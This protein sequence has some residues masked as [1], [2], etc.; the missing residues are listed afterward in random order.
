MHIVM[1]SINPLFPGHVMGGASKHLQNIAIHLG[2]SGHDVTVLCT[3]REDTPQPFHWHER[4]Q[5]LPLLRFKTPVSQSYAIPAYD[6]A[7]AIQ[8]VGEYLTKADR[9]YIHDGE[10]LFPYVFRH[11]P[12]VV[13]LRDNIYPETLLGSFLFQSDTLILIS[14]Y[15]KAYFE[16]TVGRFFPEYAQRIKV[17]YNGI[18]WE[19]FCPV[20]PTKILELI[21]VDPEKHVII[22]HPHRP[23][24][25]KGI[26]QTIRVVDLL[27]HQYGISNIRILVP[28]SL[29]TGLSTDLRAFYDKIQDDIDHRDLSENFIFHAWMSQELMPEYYS[30]GDVTLALGSFVESFGNA[31]YESLGCGTP[32]VVTR[33]GSHREILPENLVDKVDFG[34][35]E[36]TAE[37][38]AR[39]IR[40]KERTSAETLAYLRQNYSVDRQLAAYADTILNARVKDE[41]RYELTSLDEKTYFH[42]APW[43][44]P[45]AKGI[46]H[47]FRADYQTSEILLELLRAYPQGFNTAQAQT[48][49]TVD[50]MMNWYRDGYLVP[51]FNA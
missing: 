1:F 39:I 29:D 46:Y 50:E 19:K 22:L 28:R 21:H 14:D 51:Q 23:D 48:L 47:D 44:Y 35:V 36:A 8:D 26:R 2:K 25:T 32:A 41:L 9:F 33:V 3:R 18:D 15:A 10:F 49:M 34:D 11:I 43:C 13:S 27:A 37:I 20:Q 31:V 6:M 4:V 40:Q 45:S 30:L 17:I 5:I 7:A 38:A 12:T 16:Q 24:Y 42:L